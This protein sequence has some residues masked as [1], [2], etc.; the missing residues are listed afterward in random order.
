MG[1]L[2]MYVHAT[3]ARTL[4][5]VMQRTHLDARSAFRE[6]VQCRD[7]YEETHGSQL[8]NGSQLKEIQ[9]YKF[10]LLQILF[11]LREV[12]IKY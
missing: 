2:F 7:A 1:S 9:S 8:A 10:N 12:E 3:S 6:N 4:M 5:I 11:Y